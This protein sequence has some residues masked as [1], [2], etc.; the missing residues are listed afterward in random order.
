MGDR[1]R[2]VAGGDVLHAQLVPVLRDGLGRDL[3]RAALARGFRDARDAA[4]RGADRLR[5]RDP[6]V[7]AVGADLRLPGR[8]HRRAVV[9]VADGLRAARRPRPAARHG[10]AGRPGAD[11]GRRRRRAADPR[12]ARAGTRRADPARGRRGHRAD[13]VAGLAGLARVG[14]PLPRRRPRAAAARRLGRAGVRGPARPRRAGDR[15]ADGD[16]RRRAGA[17]EQRARCGA[18]DH[19]EPQRGRSRRLDAARAGPGAA[20]LP[21]RRGAL[22]DPHRRHARPRGDRLAR[23][24]AAARPR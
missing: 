20:P 14:E 1:R 22:R 8:P 5:R 16:R 17:E 6:A 24:H 18:G 11:G 3:A 4:A 19:A 15:R 12:R 2:R 23:R 9:A 21:A 10:R 7:A 13:R